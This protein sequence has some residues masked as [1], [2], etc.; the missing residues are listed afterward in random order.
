MPDTSQPSASP[1]ELGNTRTAFAHRSN[2]ELLKMDLLFSLMNHPGLNRFAIGSLMWAIRWNLPVKFLVKSTIFNHFCG[3]ESIIEC[4][5]T[6]EKLAQSGV[7]TILDYSVEG[8]KNEEGFQRVKEETLETISTAAE[9]KEIPFAVFKTSGIV[10]SDLLEKFQ[11]GADLSPPEQTALE[12]GRKRFAEI[13][14]A[15]SAAGVRLFVDAEES[16]IQGIIDQWTYEEMALHNRAR[17][18]VFNTYQLYRRNVLSSLKEAGLL[19]K[20]EGY[21]VGAK[22]VRGAYMEKEAAYAEKEGM[23]NPIQPDKAS[24]DRDYNAA[25][26]FCLQNLDCIHFCAGSHNE[27]SNHLLASRMQEMGLKKNDERIWFAQ[28]L[29]MSDNISFTLAGLGYNVAKYVPYGPVF[30]VMPYL[31][32]RAAENTSVAG[33]TSRELALIQEERKRRKSV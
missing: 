30:S 25:V 15:A 4:L 7:G 12:A 3:G 33:Q 22:L 19:A 8:E 20:S 11:K 31:I 10:S 2:T 5:K 26:E 9:R 6:S 27:D 14:R 28:L 1:I 21:F 13:C 17:P 32:R 23:Q 29:G 16:W 18:I 24:S